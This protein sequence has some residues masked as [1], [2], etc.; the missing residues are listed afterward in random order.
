[1]PYFCLVKQEFPCSGIPLVLFS[2]MAQRLTSAL[3]ES[4]VRAC[5][6]KTMINFLPPNLRQTQKCACTVRG[7]G[8]KVDKSSL[9]FALGGRCLIDRGTFEG[10]YKDS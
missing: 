5:S 1:M 6:Q 10:R 3:D 4:A 7:C 9:S 2:A 8:F